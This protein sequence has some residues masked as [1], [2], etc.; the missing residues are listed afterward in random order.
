MRVNTKQ[1]CLTGGLPFEPISQSP[2]ISD[3]SKF[4]YPLSLK[5]HP[6]HTSFWH[7]TGVHRQIRKYPVDALAGRVT[8]HR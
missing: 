2:S 8:Y 7:L 6:N 5:F 3:A 4:R 1:G